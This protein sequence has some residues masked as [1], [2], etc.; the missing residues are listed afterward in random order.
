MNNEQIAGVLR[1][2][3][4]LLEMKGE[5]RF[6][7]VAFQKV[8]RAVAY[9]T[10]DVEQLA[11]EG[12]LKEIPGVGKGI[13]SKIDE[14]L[15]TGRIEEHDRL[16][17]DLPDGVLRMLDVSGIGPKTAYRICD[18]LGVSTLEGLQNAIL[19][20]R[21]EVLPGM[22]KKTAENI[23]RRL[24]RPIAKDGRIL[25]GKALPIAE[26]VCEAMRPLVPNVTE[27]GSLRRLEETV[28]DI[29][30]LGTSDD[31]A[32]AIE[33]FVLLPF[34]DE[35]LAHGP[36]KASVIVD[37]AY[38]VDLRIVEHESFGN[39]LQHFSGSKEHNVIL[40]ERARRMGLSVN[41]YGITDLATGK[42]ERHTTEEEVYQRLGLPWIPPELRWGTDEIELAEQG[43]LP[44]LV[45][46]GDLKGDLHCHSEWSD[47]RDSLETVRE[48]A[49]AQGY[50]YLAITDHSSGRGVANGLTVDRLMDQVERVH[51]LDRKADDG[52]RLLAGSEVDIRADGSLDFPDEALERLDGAGYLL[53]IATGKARRGLDHML[54][55]HGLRRLFTG[56]QTADDAPSKP[57]PGMV[58]NCLAATGVA[59]AEAV[60]VGDTEFDMAMARAAG[61]RAVGVDWGYHSTERLRRGGAERIVSDFAALDAVL[62]QFLAK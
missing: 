10:D 22:G 40:R 27:A 35:V 57:H 54:D 60:V 41:E 59:A 3:A 25:L 51:D 17:A 29:D 6:K 20:G 28:G 37:D 53:S 49:R 47:G 31:P 44:T 26:R 46:L 30:I 14:L 48:Q 13:A 58:L 62:E 18:E 38:Q 52:F 45:A 43:R 42:V 21:L 24:R 8:A 39:L 7:V 56:T 36:T 5:V 55:S 11:S 4:D 23:L 33:A 32:G 34:V 15:S 9:A 50:D 61:V 1:Q 2:M 12:R 19:A 16:V